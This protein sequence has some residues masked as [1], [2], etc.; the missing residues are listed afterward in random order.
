MAWPVLIVAG[1]LE[2]VWAYTMKLSHG[3]TRL[4]P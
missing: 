3:F 1:L 4:G 2:I